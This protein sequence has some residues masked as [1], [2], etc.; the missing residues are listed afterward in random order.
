MGCFNKQT[1]PLLLM[2]LVSFTG[3]AQNAPTYP[4]ND[5]TLASAMREHVKF[6]ADDKL[7]GRL[8]GSEG[9]NK[10]AKYIRQQ[11]KRYGLKPANGKS[12][13]QSFSFNRVTYNFKRTYLSYQ[14][15]FKPGNTKM[16]HRIA[17]QQFYPMGFS[18]IGTVTAPVT[19]VGY[20]IVS[21][22]EYNDYI[23]VG[24]VKGRIVVI[25]MGYPAKSSSTEY[26]KFEDISA[27][28]DTAI[29]RGAAGIIFLNDDSANIFPKYKPYFT[30]ASMA[31][32]KQVP[33]VFFPSADEIENLSLYDV[34][35]SIDTVTET[36][37]GHNVMG[38][39][40]NR[41]ANTVVIGAHYDHLGYNEL[42]GST[43]N[44]N[45]VEY[46]RIHNGADDNASGTATMMAL[47]NSL[48][49]SSFTNYNYLFVAFS[50]EEEGLLGSNYFTK[51]L[52]VDSSTLNYMINL[53]MVG[54]L[55]S[56][57][58]YSIS[59]MGTSPTWTPLM[60]SFSKGN[61]HIKYD[62]AGTGASD[63]TSFYNIGI[64]ALH[65]FTGTH[66]DYHK[67][68]DD[69]WRIN[70]VGMVSIHKHI[71]EVI[72]KADAEPKLVFTPTKDAHSGRS[73]YKVTLGIMPDYLFEGKGI[74]IDGTTPGKPASIA[75][76]QRGDIIIKMGAIPTPDMQ[77][78]M[79]A[80]S[81]FEKGNSAPVTLIRNG[82]TI[83]IT[84]VF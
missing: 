65:Y 41:A 8:V 68:S 44:T 72:A 29:A 70:Y 66:Y 81:K 21:G 23:H 76:I 79:T 16:W 34:T 67:P 56:L 30:A 45:K 61:I 5:A 27:K 57:K 55:D 39:I 31:T 18:G 48:S 46:P 62:Q 71:Y 58:G 26:K 22:G 36:I 80:L 33:I 28:A 83:E 9:E 43:F 6:L 42:G 19:Y 35:I 47:A 17:Y 14:K 52:P 64:P 84:V 4:L 82:Q 59:G 7:E 24:S 63:H 15:N 50:G 53:D 2:L 60:D 13:I 78:Y 54:R 11:F 73:T 40:D 12:Y 49:L 1:Y 32:R 10:A 38:L 3:R 74:K 25:N 51:H 37:T 77:S 69:E 75:G 20:G